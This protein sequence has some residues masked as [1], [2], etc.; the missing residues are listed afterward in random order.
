MEALATLAALL[1]RTINEVSSLDGEYQNQ[2]KEAVRK[3]EEELHGKHAESVELIRKEVL[4]E[5][6]RRSQGELQ[7]ALEML[8]SDFQNERE[9]I[10][11]EFETER[12]RLNN[13]L[14][15]AGNSAAEMQ[16]ERSKL[17]A[18]LQR[19][20]D[21]AAA[22]LERIRSEA[23]AAAA[24]AAP[25]QA[26]AREVSMPN[27]EIESVEKKLAEVTRLVEDPA[28]ELSVVIRK[29]VEKLE[30]EAYLKGLR[31]IAQGKRK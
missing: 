19:V 8:R 13:E 17:S 18:E 22:E 5:L 7:T 21:H 6:T 10:K 31:Y 15:A 11:S 28:T 1:E 23:T 12:E 29:N 27:E 14:H 25:S 20:K 26:A 4:D 16:V 24:S 30:L 2:I 9:R 3:R